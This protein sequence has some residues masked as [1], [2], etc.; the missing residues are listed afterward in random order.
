MIA[1]SFALLV[2]VLAQDQAAAALVTPGAPDF[3]IKT[4]YHIDDRYHKDAPSVETGTLKTCSSW[5]GKLSCCTA[6]MT[7]TLARLNNSLGLYNFTYA[8]CD[9]LSPQCAQYMRVCHLQ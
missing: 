7:T 4:D 5:Q 6:A 8:I 1:L 9:E 2:A 3:C